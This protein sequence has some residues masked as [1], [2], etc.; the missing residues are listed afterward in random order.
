MFVNLRDIRKTVKIF[1]R[2]LNYMKF[3]RNTYLYT[4]MTFYYFHNLR[5]R[6]NDKIVEI[7]MNYKLNRFEGVCACNC[8]TYWWSFFVYWTTYGVR[9]VDARFLFSWR[10]HPHRLVRP[11]SWPSSVYIY[12]Y[13]CSDAIT[14][15]SLKTFLVVWNAFRQI[16]RRVRR[17]ANNGRGRGSSRP[18]PEYHRV[19]AAVNKRAKNDSKS[20]SK[21]KKSISRGGYMRREPWH[22]FFFFFIFILHA[23]LNGMPPIDGCQSPSAAA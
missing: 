19:C 16:I 11:T 20:L 21:P 9:T 5:N 2:D 23:P 12:V 17:C 1:R 10:M 18:W 22:G 4:A 13:T 15:T 14:T 6:N 3:V 7:L 8:S